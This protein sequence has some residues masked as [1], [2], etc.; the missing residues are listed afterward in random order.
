MPVLLSKAV[1]RP[2]LRGLNACDV[3]SRLGNCL[4]PGETALRKLQKSLYFYLSLLCL[5]FL[6]LI[7]SW[8]ATSLSVAIPVIASQLEATTLESFWAS[9]S[10][11]LGVVVAQPIHASL[12][13]VLGRKVP[14][15]IS[16]LLF[17]TGSIV[18]ATAPNMKA[19]IAGRILQGLGGGGLDILESIILT[20]ITT[21]KE[22]PLYLGVMAIPITAGS[23]LG[24]IL[25]ALLSEFVDWR[26]IGWINL[27]F[28]GIAFVLTYFLRLKP[29]N[30]NFEKRISSLDYKGLLLFALGAT[31]VVLPL[32]WSGSLYPWSSWK[33]IVPLVIGLI[34]LVVF[35]FHESKP[36]EVMMP[37]RIFDN[38]TSVMALLGGFIHGLVMYNMLLYFPLFFQA[39][40]LQAP[41]RSAQ[42]ILLACGITLA[43]SILAPLVVQQTR[44]YRLQLQMGWIFSTLSLG[45]WCSLSE[46]SSRAK[47]DGIQA[48][49]GVGIGTV[50]T[51]IAIPIQASVKNVDD[52]GHAAG[53]LII[54]RIFG[55]VIGL[56][57]SS[58]VFS[59]VFQQHITALTP[60]PESLSYLK[61]GSQAIS[62]IPYLRILDIEDAAVNTLINVYS[63]AFRA[64]WTVMAC[65]SGI[66]LLSSFFIKDL[67]LERE[68]LGVGII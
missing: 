23:L 56:A 53:M 60:L 41:L 47:I 5:A 44:R 33:S 50:F 30:I 19:V 7:V 54:F 57:T 15:H 64:I 61:D 40:F 6:V 28:V 34:V 24:P 14:L 51:T 18:F 32:S 11:L 59:N 3:P 39:I 13:N 62:F 35:G 9:I 26:W 37:L 66:G 25:G 49:L 58:A 55:A 43:L 22:R 31:A 65:L 29:I 4:D 1:V 63:K 52:A 27:P 48:M 46:T 21:L 10:F 38:M 68:N 16:M 42:S 17:A 8:D 2:S 20:D 67:D 12:S 36:G 45:L